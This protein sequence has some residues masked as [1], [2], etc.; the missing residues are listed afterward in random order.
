MMRIILFLKER[1]K[2]LFASFGLRI[3]RLTTKTYYDR[4]MGDFLEHLVQL[5]FDPRTVIDVGV[6]YGTP[7]LYAKFP[8]SRH[9]LVEP[10]REWENTLKRICRKHNAEYVLAAAG[11]QSGQKSIHI[12]SI[13]SNS[14]FYNEL[15]Q[16]DDIIDQRTIP[17]V[18]L[19]DLCLE[20]GMVPPYLIKIDVQG[21]ELDVLNGA[22]KILEVTEV[23]ILEVSLFAV[24]ENGPECSEVV[25]YMRNHGF[26]LYDVFDFIRRSLDRAV[27]QVNMAFVK[28]KGVFRQSKLWMTPEGRKE[29]VRQFAMLTNPPLIDNQNCVVIAGPGLLGIQDGVFN[30]GA[31]RHKAEIV[32]I[33]N[34]HMFS[35]K[36]ILSHEN[37]FKGNFPVLI[38]LNENLEIIRS[39]KISIDP[40]L[41][42]ELNKYWDYRLFTFQGKLYANHFLASYPS[43]EIYPVDSRDRKDVQLISEV[44]LE[45][46]KIRV[47]GTPI[48]DF[49]PTKSEKNW[50]Y[51][52]FNNELYLLYSFSPY[53]LLKAT[54]WQKREFKTIRTAEINLDL[55]NHD[56]YLN[57]FLS[58]NPIEY[59]KDY[60]LV[61]FH[62]RTTPW[63]GFYRHWA[64]LISKKSLLPEKISVR[65]LLEGGYAAGRHPQVLY[66]TSALMMKGEVVFFLGE[67]DT[68]TSYATIS[69]KDLDTYFVSI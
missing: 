27:V 36:K 67:G 3:C 39:E 13:L 24:Y 34:G 44:F 7:E 55:H 35:T 29:S 50:T 66:V 11:A 15:S 28:E 5:G 16:A 68:Y 69:K 26:V 6:A 4:S 59:D 37:Y 38:N 40:F 10:L 48:L 21:N 51:F 54:N 2:K 14:T 43:N 57:V 46:N 20:K 32:L 62:V 56:A 45:E 58:T 30:P 17:V 60:F 22:Q 31:I 63:P 8:R 53:K 18:T 9:L 61:T 25:A 47:L 12:N 64:A 49:P 33:A 1:G 19:D 52:E 23:V 41:P 42:E 65:P